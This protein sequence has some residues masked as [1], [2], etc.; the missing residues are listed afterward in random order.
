MWEFLSK[1]A[2]SVRD[3]T[4]TVRGVAEGVR[5]IVEVRLRR[6]RL[7]SGIHDDRAEGS[8]GRESL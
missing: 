5:N 1:Y 8:M 3:V 7:L 6:E 4:E 2:E